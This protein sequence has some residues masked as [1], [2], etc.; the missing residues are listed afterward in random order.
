MRE[1]KCGSNLGYDDE[2]E[3]YQLG[4]TDHEATIP[5]VH[6]QG[7]D[8]PSGSGQQA[9][10]ERAKRSPMAEV[11]EHIY[12]AATRGVLHDCL[13]LKQGLP[14][15]SVI[16]WKIMEYLPFRRMDLQPD[17][18]WK[19]IWWPLPM[20]EVRDIPDY[21]WIH[22]SA[23]RRMEANES[24]RPGNLIVGGGGRGVRVAPKEYGMGEWEVVHE[25]GDPVGECV[26]RVKNTGK[27]ENGNSEQSEKN[28]SNG[29][30]TK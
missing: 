2:A 3:E 4:P 12:N 29:K 28:G 9:N 19:S 8:S 24:Y 6:I 14:T 17:G 11:H 25:K 10:G 18:S 21:A 15:S 5:E 7:A 27:Q 23:L 13:M 20:G 16:P 22:T 30:R 1:M 26:V